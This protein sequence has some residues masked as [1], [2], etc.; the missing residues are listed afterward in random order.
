MQ[1][2]TIPQAQMH[3][4]SGGQCTHDHGQKPVWAG[5]WWPVPAPGPGAAGMGIRMGMRIG[6]GMGIQD[7]IFLPPT[8][9]KFGEEREDDEGEEAVGWSLFPSPIHL[10][11]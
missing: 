5:C 1:A 10:L 7:A 2:Q 8:V 3:G 4:L 9:E 11:S 6:M